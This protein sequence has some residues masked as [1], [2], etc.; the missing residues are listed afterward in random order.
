MQLAPSVRLPPGGC[1]PPTPGGC[2]LRRVA[3]AAAGRMVGDVLLGRPGDVI[4]WAPDEYVTRAHAPLTATQAGRPQP[5]RFLYL[6]GCV[7]EGCGTGAGAWRAIRCQ[8]QCDTSSGAAATGNSRDASTAREPAAN[9]RAAAEL[10]DAFGA[11]ATDDWGTAG[12]AEDWGAAGAGDWGVG[13]ADGA[14]AGPTEGLDFGDL[15]AALDALGSRP[16]GSDRGGKPRP[17]SAEPAAERQTAPTSAA[18]PRPAAAAEAPVLPGF[19]LCAEAEAALPAGSTARRQTEE[20]HLR[21]LLQRYEQEEQGQ[22]EAAAPLGSGSAAAAAIAC[23]PEPEGGAE[24]WAGEGYEEDATDSRRASDAAQL[25]FF[26]RLGRC[27]DQ[28]VRYSFGGEPLWPGRAPPVAQPCARC[29]G[30]RVFELQLMTPA[31][32]YLEESAD[33]LAE[34]GG[35]EGAGRVLRPPAGW[36]WLTVAAL[37]CRGSCGPGA[38]GTEGGGGGCYAEEQV[39]LAQNAWLRAFVSSDQFF[40]SCPKCS[41]R[42]SQRDC[43]L[44]LWAMNAQIEACSVCAID[45]NA[46]T[47]IQVRRSSYHDVVKMADISRLTDIAG[48]Q[49]YTINGSKV[50]FLRRRPQPRPPKGA[51]GNSTCT[52]CT[53]HLQDV[54]LFCSL[55]CKLD[56]LAGVK[57]V[58]LRPPADAAARAS[59][60]SSAGAARS[61]S[62]RSGGPGTPP[63][64]LSLRAAMDT[65]SDSDA[66]SESTS[67]GSRRKAPPARAHFD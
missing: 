33:W 30:P 43:C 2:R 40:S 28:C 26:K 46:D 15:N 52:I 64:P 9:S 27:P 32:P 21:H 17:A 5:E 25:K 62:T 20:A 22:V 11:A 14:S 39:E 58:S 38:A 63:H 50:V 4:T 53:R 19:V 7:K 24:S 60:A 35:A 51:V 42:A 54:S 12:A 31:I 37:T 18:P 3:L 13:G 59:A 41:S 66:M 6:L 67:S 29:G 44:N 47:L 10:G 23:L 34:Q 36:D 16:Q 48:I 1:P 57:H 65:G 8:L 49:P 61:D 45:H 56:A 55:Q